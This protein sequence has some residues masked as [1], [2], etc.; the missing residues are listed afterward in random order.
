[1]AEMG[2]EEDFQTPPAVSIPTPQLHFPGTMHDR[3]ARMRETWRSDKQRGKR[4]QPQVLSPPTPMPSTERTPL[5]MPRPSIPSAFVPGTPESD[6]TVMPMVA[7]PGEYLSIPPVQNGTLSRRPSAISI[8][9]EKPIGGKS[10]FG[11]TVCSL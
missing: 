5:L 4:K 3:S 7:E 2:W 11:Q 9:A 8:K 6:E 1:M 10:T